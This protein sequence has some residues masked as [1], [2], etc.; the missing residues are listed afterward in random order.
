MSKINRIKVSG[1]SY[2][3]EDLNARQSVSGKA[4]QS[5]LLTV[6]GDVIT[7]S[8]DVATNTSNISTVSAST[9]N[10]TTALGGLKLVK[11]TQSAYDALSPN[12]DSS[13][14]YIING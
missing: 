6:S 9:A 4:S 12:Y 13:T 1:T 7:I 14:L 8:G 5:A 2:D 10:N 11:L 3:I